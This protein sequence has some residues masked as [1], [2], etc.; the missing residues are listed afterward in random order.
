M[1]KILLKAQ[2]LGSL[3]GLII[4]PSCADS[5][6]GKTVALVTLAQVASNV[7]NAHLDGRK[8]S[9]RTSNR[10]VARS[11][12]ISK[13][14]EKCH[15]SYDRAGDTKNECVEVNENNERK[16]NFVA[17]NQRG[18]EAIAEALEGNSI[19]DI[20]DPFDFAEAND[21]SLESAE[22]FSEALDDAKEGDF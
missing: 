10:P 7:G 13:T 22:R 9:G 21:L 12:S 16:L 3:V 4:L 17:L 15:V 8:N 14:V 19:S 11:Q 6:V 1:K 2:L 5:V 18:F 20:V